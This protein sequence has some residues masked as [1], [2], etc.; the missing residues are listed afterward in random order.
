[1][2]L[3]PEHFNKTTHIGKNKNGI[4]PF[5]KGTIIAKCLINYYIFS[6]SNSIGYI[7]FDD[8]VVLNH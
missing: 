4:K 7:C 6:F 5:S 2:K 1:M 8:K 3:N